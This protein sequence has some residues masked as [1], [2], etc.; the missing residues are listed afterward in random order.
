TTGVSGDAATGFVFNPTATTTYTLTATNADGCA[1]VADIEV[2]VNPNPGTPVITASSNSVCIGEVQ[3]LTA[4]APA[5]AVAILG[6]GTTSPG[7]T[8]YPNP[9]SA[10]Y[11]GAKHQIIY[12]AAELTAQ[13]LLPGSQIST[14]SFDL[15]N[16]ASNAATNFTIRMWNTSLT[17]LTGFITGTTTVYGPQTFTPSATGI[18]TFTLSTP[19]TWN[20][21]S[22][23][24][25]E[26]VHNAGNGGNGS[27]TRTATTTTP[28]NTVFYG[29]RDN[30]SGG[31][32]GFDSQTSYTSTGASPLRPNV[33]FGFN[34]SHPIWT[35]ANLYTDAA[36]TIPYTGTPRATVYA[37]P[38]E[39]TTYVATV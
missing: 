34:V 11:G 16:F 35:G 18:V 7:T 32:A 26:T 36:A 31:I 3:M 25:V 21:T 8:S 2:T 39:T 33:R 20:G 38:T 37:K 19:F 15:T 5:S 12:R 22:N 29:A 13:G 27:G 9:L 28:T 4:T 23:I 6:T 14:I 24:V 30:V 10:Y 1:N 17:A